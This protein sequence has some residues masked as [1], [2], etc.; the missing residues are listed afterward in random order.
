MAKNS[1]IDSFSDKKLEDLI[2]ICISRLKRSEN[3]YC[4]VDSVFKVL[5]DEKLKRNEIY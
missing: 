3:T 4:F 2:D 1:N 5:L